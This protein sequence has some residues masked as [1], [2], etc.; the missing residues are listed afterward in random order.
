MDM[1]V[2]G[3]AVAAA[4]L[5]GCAD[6]DQLG[7]DGQPQAAGADQVRHAVHAYTQSAPVR[8]VGQYADAVGRGLTDSMLERANQQ[9]LASRAMA[10][11]MN[12]PRALADDEMCV[13]SSIVRVDR[14][15][16][17]PSYTQVLQGGR[18]IYCKDSAY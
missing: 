14:S 12:A 15:A 4:L 2:W 1:R 3:F 5:G 11:H 6:G 9:G 7:P 13:G 16:N 17:P 18:P 8:R 10:K